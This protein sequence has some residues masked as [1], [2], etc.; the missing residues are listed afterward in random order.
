MEE[1]LR[2]LNKIEGV[3]GS[4][5]VSNEGLMVL[6]LLPSDVDPDA[7]AGMAASNFRNSSTVAK[8]LNAGKTRKVIIE[9]DTDFIIFSTIGN[10]FLA[11]I[12]D[13][14]VNLG[15]LK[16]RIEKAVREIKAK[17]LEG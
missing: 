17:I 1:Q 15:L 10:G 3:K 2:N 13:K 5:I 14:N 16:I 11:V 8:V 4:A 12:S 9:T 7:V 6:S